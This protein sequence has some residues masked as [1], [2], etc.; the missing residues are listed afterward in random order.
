MPLVTL[1]LWEYEIA[2]LVGT[3]RTVAAQRYGR[4]HKVPQTVADDDLIRHI[5]GAAAEIAVGKFLGRYPF[6]GEYDPAL[7][8]VHPDIEVRQ[9][10]YATGGLI[11]R[12]GLDHAERPYV[13]VRGQPPV[14]EV[15]GW[16][17]G[18]Q[19]MQEQWKQ[20]PDSR[21]A[22]FLVPAEAL[23]T[24]FKIRKNGHDAD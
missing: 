12:P 16:M 22:M 14:F 19:A 13:L 9:T 20:N 18:R 24:D 7:A 6:M 4:Q 11:I 17:K 10:K 1:D 2:S 3:K 23:C 15:V 21:G 5:C 8:D